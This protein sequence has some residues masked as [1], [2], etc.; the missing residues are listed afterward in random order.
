MKHTSRPQRSVLWA[1]PLSLCIAWLF[2]RDIPSYKLDLQDNYAWISQDRGIDLSQLVRQASLEPDPAHLHSSMHGAIACDIPLCSQLGIDILDKGGNAADASVTVALCVGGLN[3]F[4]SGIGGGAYF[5]AKKYDEDAITIDARECAPLKSDKLMFKGREHLSQVGGLAAGIPG[6]IKGLYTLF[7]LQ[8]S[9]NLEWSELI[10]PVVNLL[11]NGWNAS[12]VLA[13]VV[14]VDKEVLKENYDDYY[15]LFKENS[16]SEV[17]ELGDIIKHTEL[18]NTL[19]LV[20]KNGSDAIFYDPQGPIASNLITAVNAHGGIFTAEDFA[21]YEVDI[22]PALHTRFINN[23]VYTSCGS[24]SGPALVHGLSIMDHFGEQPGG[25][26]EPFA[27]HRLIESMKWM[28]SSR[29]RLGDPETNLTQFVI[30]EEWA[31]YAKSHLNDS[32][33]MP[34]W[35]D[36]KPVYEINTPHGTTSFAIVDKHHNA[37]G[38]TSTINLLF[39]SLVRDPI[40]GIILNNEMDDFSTPGSPNAFGVE[41][42][43]HNFIR[44]KKRPLSSSVPTIVVN[45]LGKPDFIIAAAG[46]SRILTAV[47]QAIVRVY[48]Y[49][50]PILETIAYPRLHHQLLPDV[51]EHEDFIGSDIIEAL[52]E[53]GHKLLMQPPKTA[54]NGIRRW[55]GD[56][57]AVSDF[58]RKRAEAAVQEF[59]PRS[60]M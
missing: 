20:A 36:Y 56:Y 52:G 16:T 5:V 3:M 46:G 28:A 51:I 15:F 30:S 2:I 19:E 33:S 54:M 27:T 25:D 4:N 47:F 57:H 38:C 59:D 26:M 42:S 6:E 1:L 53:K 39:G 41:P 11:R 18:A 32:A 9:G 35:S 55:Q 12:V 17:I 49:Q 14:E 60:A 10:M 23:D 43:V 31:N 21:Q 40:T 34:H 50:M 45:E 22:S 24:S 13:S 58:W 29:S 8:G 37:V 48:S 44:P 7:E